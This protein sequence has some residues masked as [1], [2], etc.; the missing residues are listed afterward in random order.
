MKS[1]ARA[2]RFALIFQ[3]ESILRISMKN[4]LTI[5]AIILIPACLAACDKAANS[6]SPPTPVSEAAPGAAAPAPPAATPDSTQAKAP[7]IFSGVY[8]LTEIEDKSMVKMWPA[9]NKVE[10][11]FHPDGTYA[12]RSMNRGRLDH[13]DTGKYRVDGGN[14]LTLSI[15]S[16]DNKTQN[17]AKEIKHSITWSADGD[18]LKLTSKDG[19]IATFRK[20]GESPSN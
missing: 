14:Q 12:R 16:S 1:C 11:I 17:P 13:I 15:V 10:F 19:K 3:A 2:T 8:T 5:L 7:V 6:T 9:E 4:L 20:T 18:S